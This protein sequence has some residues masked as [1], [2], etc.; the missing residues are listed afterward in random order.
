MQVANVIGTVL[1]YAIFGGL[2]YG[3]YKLISQVGKK[4]SSNDTEP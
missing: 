2:I 4:Q 3:I 1:G